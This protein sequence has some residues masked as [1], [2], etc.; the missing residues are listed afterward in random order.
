LGQLAAI[1]WITASKTM[2]PQITQIQA[3]A[4]QNQTMRLISRQFWPKRI[5]LRVLRDLRFHFLSY[6]D[7]L[8]TPESAN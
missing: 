3:N 2:K 4:S 6:C 5:H 8:A 1:S 7:L